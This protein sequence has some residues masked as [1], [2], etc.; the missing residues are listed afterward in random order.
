MTTKKVPF[1]MAGWRE[2]FG[3]CFANRRKKLWHTQLSY[4]LRYEND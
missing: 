2:R 1:K 3:F 4:Y